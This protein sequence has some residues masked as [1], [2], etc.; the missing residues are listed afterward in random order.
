MLGYF[1]KN[2]FN[3]SMDW[4]ELEN[5]VQAFFAEE[6]RETAEALRREIEVLYRLNNPELIREVSYR[7]GDRGMPDDR[8]IK[9]IALLYEKACNH[10]D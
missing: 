5:C 9:M 7:L 1:I 6:K 2:Y 8:A 4:A 3:C 10:P